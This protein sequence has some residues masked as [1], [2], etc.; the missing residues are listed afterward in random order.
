MIVKKKIIFV[1]ASLLSFLLFVHFS[2]TSVSSI[3]LSGQTSTAKSVS[4][5]VKI[6]ICGNNIA[7]GG[8]DCDNTDLGGDTCITLGYTSG[9]LSCDIACD[10]NTSGCSTIPDSTTST[11]TSTSEQ[12]TTTTSTTPITPDTSIVTSPITHIPPT[13]P[14]VLIIPPALKFFDLDESGKIEV[15]EVFASVKSWVD[16]WRDALI[17]EIAV[18]KGEIFEKK[19]VKR[20]DVNNDHRCNLVDLSILLFYIQK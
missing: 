1:L 15:T 4:A 10:F 13:T 2:S 8:E 16:E 12:T 17:E 9:T 5:T 6:S 3:S 18:A 19:E 7:E 20:C 14:S 11:E